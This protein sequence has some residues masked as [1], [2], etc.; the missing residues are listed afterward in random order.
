MKTKK[1]P[2][3]EWVI[4][5]PGEGHWPINY[6]GYNKKAARRTYLKWAHRKR[7]PAGSHISQVR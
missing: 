5:I 1:K 6:D 4:Y 2:E 7:L 3:T